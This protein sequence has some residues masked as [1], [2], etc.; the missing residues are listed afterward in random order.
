MNQ[1]GLK[2]EYLPLQENL[3]RSVCSAFFEEEDVIAGVLLGSL[4]AGRGDRVSDADII[5]FTQNDFHKYAESCFSSFEAGREAFYCLDGYHNENAYFRK[6]IFHDMTSAEIHCFDS[7]EPFDIC[8]PLQVLFDKAG[9]VEG[10]LTEE[11]VPKHEDFPVYTNG[12]KGLIW[13]LFD[14]IKWLSRGENELAKSYLKK[15]SAKI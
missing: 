7:C 15:L 9:V 13:E 2:L 12:D 4:A 3:V 1:E 11:P 8:R 10:K 14:C 6:Y 5:L